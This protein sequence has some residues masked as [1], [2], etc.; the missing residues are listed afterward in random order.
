MTEK[1][2]I[3]IGDL[4]K[5]RVPSE[6]S[7]SPNGK[8]VVFTVERMDKEDNKYYRNIHIVETNGRNK[9]QLTFGRWNDHSP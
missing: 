1:R 5:F 2:P 3:R 6:P 9:K 8:R 7:V 4:Y